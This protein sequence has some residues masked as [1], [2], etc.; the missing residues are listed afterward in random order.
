MIG[1][2]FRPPCLP[3]TLSTLSWDSSCRSVASRASFIAE[4]SKHW[5][6]TG[7]EAEFK[8]SQVRTKFTVFS[9]ATSDGLGPVEVT[10]GDTGVS[11]WV[12]EDGAIPVLVCT[13][14]SSTFVSRP[15]LENLL[16]SYFPIDLQPSLQLFVYMHMWITSTPF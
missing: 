1:A 7:S 9:Q 5:S 14:G 15:D 2:A 4:M 16:L 8:S 12:C 6:C 13:Y 10:A 11:L 3:Y